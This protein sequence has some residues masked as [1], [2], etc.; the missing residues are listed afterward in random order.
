MCPE[1]HRLTH[2]VTVEVP[3]FTHRSSYSS[4]SGCGG[5][6]EYHQY[7]PIQ[8]WT[9]KDVLIWIGSVERGR[10]A[11]VVLPKDIDGKGLLQLSVS[12][13]NDLFASSASNKARNQKEGKLMMMVM[14][15]I[16]DLSK[17]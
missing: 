6:G 7:K 15:M 5:G 16:H 2:R 12:R 1:L 11:H 13:L 8:D 17:S 4:S 9:S 14:M 10:F 3:L